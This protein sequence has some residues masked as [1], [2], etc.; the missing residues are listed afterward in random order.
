MGVIPFIQ[1]QRPDADAVI[2]TAMGRL[3]LDPGQRKPDYDPTVSIDTG[4]RA[5]LVQQIQDW[6][7]YLEF[8]D[9]AWTVVRYIKSR[10][11]LGA[12]PLGLL[13]FRGSRLMPQ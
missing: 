1:R 11:L 13:A 12:L 6:Q 3:N 4:Q 10:P 7:R 8:A 2:L 9:H 5:A